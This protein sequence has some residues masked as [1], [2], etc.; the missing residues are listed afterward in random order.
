MR[1][2]KSLRLARALSSIV[3]RQFQDLFHVLVQVLAF[4]DDMNRKQLE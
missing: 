1:G 3:W 4:I 2:G